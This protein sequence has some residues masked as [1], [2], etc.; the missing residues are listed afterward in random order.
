LLLVAPII[1]SPLQGFPDFIKKLIV[2]VLTMVGYCEADKRWL[3]DNPDLALQL[4]YVVQQ[5]VLQGVAGVARDMSVTS[6][7]WSFKLR[8]SGG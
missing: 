1:V 2:Q 8:C 6:N 4:L 3:V 5:S 7:S